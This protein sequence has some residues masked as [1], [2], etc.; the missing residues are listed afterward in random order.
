MKSKIIAAL[1]GLAV[2]V[3]V[4][5]VL[6]KG[7]P[8]HYAGTIEATEV[9]LSSQVSSV[10]GKVNVEEGAKIRKG[11][12]L[13]QLLGEDIRVA[14][15]QADNN[16]QRGVKLFSAGSMDRETFDRLKFTRDDAMVRLGWC[17]I[18][19]PINGVVLT[20]Y[21]EPGELVTPGTKLLMLADLS[22]VWAYVYI[23][24]PLLGKV[25]VG[26][27]VDGIIPESD[28]RQVAGTIIKIND[29]AEFTPKN[30]QTHTERTRL[31]YGIKVEFANDNG[32]LK[33]GMTVEV[34]LHNDTTK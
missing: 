27:K 23:P 8:F 32:F 21:H 20:K 12:V 17:T 5:A 9:D 22:K 24:Q 3:T 29:E 34:R 7:K 11:D 1:I 13:V 18:I 14:A 31:V 10:I 33:P 2:I 4:V 19:S 16:Y 15:E 25:S 30:V 6:G 28:N 26:E